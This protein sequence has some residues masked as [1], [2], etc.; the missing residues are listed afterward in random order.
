MKKLA[1]ATLLTGALLTSTWASAA[2][3]SGITWDETN[4]FD[5][6]LQQSIFENDVNA[7]GDVLTAF[8]LVSFINGNS[9]ASFLT[10]ASELTFLATFTVSAVGD[11]DGD[12]LAEVVFDNGIWNFYADQ[13]AA[14]FSANNSATATDGIAFLSLAGHTTTRDLNP[15][16]A[17]SLHTGDL[18]AN[19]DGQAGGFST[20]GDSGEG[21]GAFDVVGGTAAGF[22]NTNT[23]SQVGGQGLD[24][25]N[26]DFSFTSSFQ[27]SPGDPNVLVATGEL[28]G[29]T[30]IP[31]PGILALLALGLVSLRKFGGHKS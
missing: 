26:A 12:G 14:D 27:P 6:S 28:I 19:L 17:P 15:N 8:G 20:P 2:S 25:G 23:I 29:Q 11:F 9:S 18:F 1:K 4:N 16:G 5:F 24:N 13:D 31:E 10:G 30:Q 21:D 22:F 3:V 7:V